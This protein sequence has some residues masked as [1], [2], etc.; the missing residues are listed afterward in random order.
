MAVTLLHGHA[1]NRA[2]FR[3]I[4]FYH[5]GGGTVNRSEPGMGE[6]AR[7]KKEFKTLDK[8]GASMLHCIKPLKKGK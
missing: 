4:L 8:C 3:L 1:G 5:L 2:L 7:E 6:I